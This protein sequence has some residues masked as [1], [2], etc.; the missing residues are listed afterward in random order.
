MCDFKESPP[1][2]LLTIGH[3]TLF[4]SSYAQAKF[5]LD[6]CNNGMNQVQNIEFQHGL[7]LI[8]SYKLT[9]K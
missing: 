2:F 3:L 5:G 9:I 4:F 7:E 6:I 1:E 8:K